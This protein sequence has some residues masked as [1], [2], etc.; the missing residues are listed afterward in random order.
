MTVPI[1]VPTAPI[2]HKTNF[3]AILSFSLALAPIIL[4]FIPF[5]NCLTLL[6]PLAA[7]ILGIIALTQINKSGMTQ[8]GKGLA[9]A[10]IVIG[11]LWIIIVPV[12]AV[13]GLA[14][15]GPVI[16]N[17]FNTIQQTLSAPTY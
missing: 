17:V 14:I 12:L 13:L 3:L 6:C 10:G 4:I 16:P 11:G 8:G 2:F 7:I 9:I 5:L 15:L 1:P